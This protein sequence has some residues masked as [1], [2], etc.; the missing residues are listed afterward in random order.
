[1]ARTARASVG[2]ICYH[3]INRGNRRARVF[4]N[5]ADYLAFTELTKRANARCQMRMVGYCLMPNHFH[6]VLWPREDGDLSRWVQ[7][8]LTSQVRR[9]HRVHATEG[10]VWQ[11]R[12]K[13]FP[14][15]QDDHL[16]RVLRYV[17]RNPLRAN[18]VSSAAAWPWSSLGPN[19]IAREPD[20]LPLPLPQ[21]WLELVNV[22]Q[23][24]AELDAIRKCLD[25]GK[26]FGAE[27]WQ[28]DIA[29]QL[30]LEASL[31][32]RGRPPK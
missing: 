29:A 30:G 20:C 1:M 8:L 14:I 31:K 5:D 19:R 10:R 6:F 28:Q 26:P 3:V 17:E 22:P 4:H 27:P 12:F 13:A 24:G 11:G 21:N 18:L 32:P 9:Y 2:G 25:R 23:T 16:L 7:W 15:E